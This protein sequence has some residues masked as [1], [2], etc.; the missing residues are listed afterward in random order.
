M[1]NFSPVY[2]YNLLDRVPDS[3]VSP[4]TGDRQSAYPIT[5]TDN[6]I[7]FLMDRISL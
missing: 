7:H 5:D 4:D 6:V 2:C 3:R 1:D